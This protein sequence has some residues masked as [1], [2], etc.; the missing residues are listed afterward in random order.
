MHR[1]L[2]NQLIDQDP[3][4]LAAP[5]KGT[6]ILVVSSRCMKVW[7]NIERRNNDQISTISSPLKISYFCHHDVFIS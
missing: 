3:F 4:K 6:T 1:L 5:G 7:E 2:T